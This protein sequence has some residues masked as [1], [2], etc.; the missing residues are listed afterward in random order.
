MPLP[1]IA[2]QGEQN[3]PPGLPGIDVRSTLQ[4]PWIVAGKVMTLQGDPIRRAKVRVEP[5]VAAEFR[6][7]ETDSQGEFQT[8]YWLNV[9]AAQDVAT[10]TEFSVNLTVAK[11]GFRIVRKVLDFESSA[12][13][14]RYLITLRDANEDP[15]LLS[16]ADLTSSLVPK[17]K[18]LGA[19]DGLSAKGEKDYV[20]GV[21]EFLDRNRPERALRSFAKV[22]RGDPSCVKCRV[23]LGLAELASGDWDGANGDFVEAAKESR[24]NPKAGRPEPALVLGV[25]E[26]WRHEPERAAGFL[27]EALKSDPRDPLALQELGR[28]QLLLQNHAT[29]ASYLAKA[30][31]AG[32]GPEARLMRA[33]A[34]VGAGYSGEADKEMTRYLGGKD[35]KA[36]PLRVRQIWVQLQER[37]KVEAAYAKASSVVKQPI[38][39][40]RRTPPE[41]KGLEPA[42]SQE[43]L[44]SILSAVGKNV[45]KAFQNFPNT[46]SLEQ[47][48]QEK[49]RR[50][51]KV[52]GAQDEK[53]H[54]LCLA[55]ADAWGPSFTEYR[56]DLSGQ[57]SHPHGLQEG[58][59]LTSGFVSAA[60]IFH[61]A[62]QAETTFRYLGRQKVNGR[63]TF[64]IA[65]AQ[66]PEKAR[67]YGIFKSAETR[68]T[69]FSQGLAWVDSTGYQIIRLHTDLLLPLPQI[70]LEKETT[71]ID[72]G[73]VHF[74]RIAE[75]FWLPQDV[76]VSVV[77]NGRYLR[78]EHQYSE[79]KLFNVEATEKIGTPKQSG[80]TSKQEPDSKAPH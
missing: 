71:K 4:R 50:N 62:Y 38:D 32:A 22:V 57:E 39:Y 58:F 15:G 3:P 19:S 8:E 54:Y 24:A 60:L 16:Q 77:W 56:A 31:D 23:M 61:P 69:T 47:I 72:F 46:V 5:N 6:A 35:V 51:G 64:V 14:R 34:L 7:F 17:L 36:M 65:F 67:L 45:A 30:L 76:T 11:K 2:Q 41:L 80:Q 52:G 33:E 63:D 9:A 59:M 1:L 10:V 74:S 68:M 42:T 40:L 37:K 44:D 73:E 12:N 27:L 48:H 18:S 78:N 28:S 13:P 20:R 79:F 66:R 21:G 49:L 75:A 53:F 26:S 70:E 29:A 55:P 43:Q 25:M